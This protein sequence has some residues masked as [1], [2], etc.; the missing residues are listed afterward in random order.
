MQNRRLLRLRN[1]THK[2]GRLAAGPPLGRHVQS[3]IIGCLA[4]FPAI[5]NPASLVFPRPET[6]EVD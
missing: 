2:I 1:K 3:Q 5:T 4:N 6:S